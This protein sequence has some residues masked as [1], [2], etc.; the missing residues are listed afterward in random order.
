M[1]TEKGYFA[2]PWTEDELGVLRERYGTVKALVIADQL[3]R[4]IHAIRIRAGIEGL[5][6]QGRYTLVPGYFRVIDSPEKGYLLGLLAA[7]GYVNRAG[8]VTLALHMKDRELVEMFRQE[9]AP[10]ARIT[11][12]GETMLRC[13]VQSAELAA[14][15][16]AW[17]V[18]PRKSLIMEWPELGPAMGRSYL[19]GYF[20][21]DGS[22]GRE[23]I[24]RWSIT[25][26]NPNFLESVQLFVLTECGIKVGGPYRDK[27][28]ANAWSI[29]ATGKPVLTLNEWLQRDGLGLARKRL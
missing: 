10:G 21:G 20:D 7:D 23:P 29:A 28:H 2:E 18:V 24:E 3:G 22:I 27:R 15:L 19:H 11:P 6:S 8:Q 17:G 9:I 13:H 4:S 1:R 12:Y 5:R 26:G 25:G 16:A 14:D